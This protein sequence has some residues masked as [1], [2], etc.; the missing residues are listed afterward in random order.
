MKLNPR[1]Y[2][3]LLY[4]L[5]YESKKSE[6]GLVIGRF[7][8]FLVLRRATALVPRI[9]ASFEEIWNEREGIISIKVT[10]ARKSSI[11]IQTALKKLFKDQKIELDEFED[12]TLL[13]GIK[14][15]IKDTIID[16]T[17]KNNLKHL[18]NLLSN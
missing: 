4:E 9:I 8:K 2:A 18:Y 17:I 12:P 11:N 3:E 7:I 14:L 16:G 10:S 13:G 5:T 15:Q 6:V 1:Q